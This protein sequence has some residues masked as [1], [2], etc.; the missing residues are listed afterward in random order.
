MKKAE[1]IA[2]EEKC[3]EL[4]VI[5]GVGVREYYKKLGYSFVGEYMMKT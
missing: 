5:S 1:E 4:F 2:R 3:S